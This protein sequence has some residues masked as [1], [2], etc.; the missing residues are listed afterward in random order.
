MPISIYVPVLIPV[1]ISIPS[2]LGS[3]NEEAGCQD[4]GILKRWVVSP[5]SNF[6]LGEIIARNLFPKV[7]NY[8]YKALRIP[9]Q[10]VVEALERKWG[11]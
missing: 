5:M 6:S 4:H 10:P 1:P 8:N 3:W 11:R 7:P 9:V 2:H